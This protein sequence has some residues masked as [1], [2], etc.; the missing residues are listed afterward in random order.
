MK[1]LTII[2]VILTTSCSTVN[3]RLDR[4]QKQAIKESHYQIGVGL[5]SPQKKFRET[6]LPEN[7]KS[8]LFSDS[9]TP[10]ILIEDYEETCGSC[11][12]HQLRFVKG[13]TIYIAKRDLFIPTETDSVFRPTYDFEKIEFEPDSENTRYKMQYGDIFEIHRNLAQNKDWNSNPFDYGTD[14]C[15]G[16]S[17]TIVS[18]IYPDQK[19]ESMYVRCW[20]PEIFLE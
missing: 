4:S 2:L 12:S 10:I 3:H 1:L 16:G 6:M 18:V 5:I 8:A 19:I 13:D 20:R 11:P 7:F 15:F 9:K 14:D 17:L